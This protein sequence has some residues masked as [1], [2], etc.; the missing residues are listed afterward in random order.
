MVYTPSLSSDDAVPSVSLTE[1]WLE[2]LGAVS[3]YG[4]MFG[5]HSLRPLPAAR[6]CICLLEAL[7]CFLSSIG[8][9]HPHFVH[10]LSICCSHIRC[11]TTSSSASSRHLWLTWAALHSEVVS[12][13]QRTLKASS[14]GSADKKSI[15]MSSRTLVDR[16]ES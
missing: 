11:H 5:D 6:N 10:F 14:V 7:S 2:T 4:V 13:E 15:R 16:Y 8:K 1:P 12:N 3:G 9:P